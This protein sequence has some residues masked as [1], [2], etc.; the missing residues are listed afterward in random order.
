MV[1]KRVCAVYVVCP[2]RVMNVSPRM[3]MSEE[4]DIAEKPR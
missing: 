3:I 2:G 4:S 1:P